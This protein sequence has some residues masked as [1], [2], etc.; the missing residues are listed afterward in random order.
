M[1][2]Y[3]SPG[4]VFVTLVFLLSGFLAILAAVCN[5]DWFFNSNNAKMITGKCRRSTAR[6]VYFVA[7][8]LILAMT[9][10]IHYRILT[11]TI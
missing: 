9:A 1:M 4:L 10:V 6:L 2:D 11:G 8:C 5:W 7:G 3:L